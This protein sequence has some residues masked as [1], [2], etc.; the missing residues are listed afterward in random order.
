M[1]IGERITGVGA[2]VKRLFEAGAAAEEST[3]EPGPVLDRTGFEGS[4]EGAEVIGRSPMS[5]L[6][7]GESVSTLFGRQTERKLARYGVEDVQPEEWYP[8]KAALA[9]LYDMRE[10]YGAAS[11]QTM[12]RSIPQHVEFPPDL[13][14]VE[15][16]LRSVDAAY[17]QNHRGGAIGS[18]EFHKDGRGEGRMVCENPYPCELDQGL[19]QGVAREFADSFVEVEEVGDTCRAEGGRR[20]EYRVDWVGE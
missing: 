16:A 17:H 1:A 19:I 4:L 2:R 18:Y 10:E 11:M 9:M 7:A 12:G 8:L 5:Y 6:A 13:T 14:G 15:E 20:C 3:Q